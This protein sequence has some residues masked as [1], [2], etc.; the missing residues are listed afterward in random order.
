MSEWTSETQHNSKLQKMDHRHTYDQA[1]RYW[2]KRCL[3]KN[4]LTLQISN[5]HMINPVIA[6]YIFND[7]QLHQVAIS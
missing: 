3:N 6:Q 5:I 7:R 4:K 1:T 2:T